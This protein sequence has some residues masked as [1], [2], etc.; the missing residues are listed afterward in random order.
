M[1]LKLKE[2][3]FVV[4]LQGLSILTI[5]LSIGACVRAAKNSFL[6][7]KLFIHVIMFQANKI[8]ILG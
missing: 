6:S 8:S 3:C 1:A 7:L 5:G 4:S 2:I